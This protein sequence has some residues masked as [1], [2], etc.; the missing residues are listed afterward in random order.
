M[1]KRSVPHADRLVG[2]ANISSKEIKKLLHKLPL[3]EKD[4]IV[5]GT[6]EVL[7]KVFNEVGPDKKSFEGLELE[8]RERDLYIIRIATEAVEKFAEQFG[9]KN[10]V[11]L[12]EGNIHYLKEGGVL[13][14]TKGRLG[15][16]S[17]ATVLGQVL[18]DRRSDLQ[19]AITTFHELWHTLASHTVIQVTTKGKLD[20]YRAGFNL[21]TRDA[22]KEYFNPIDEALVGL[23]TKKFFDEVLAKD[24]SFQDEIER[25]KTQGQKV[26]T[27][28]EEEVKML[29]YIVESIY[30]RNKDTFGSPEDVVTLFYKGQVTGN[31][32][33][34]ARVVENTF[35][36]GSFR[37]F[38]KIT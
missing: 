26:D 36:K 38:G 35:G 6:K 20:W 34:I 15:I 2:S 16:G 11:K 28:R 23:M 14:Y 13:K 17:H 9:R 1:E 22:K 8:K 37:E 29:R 12:P 30:E 25:A 21:K 3:D 24:P 19:T 32:M 5:T 27:T 33:P 4:E 18:V 10:F 31:I 7:T